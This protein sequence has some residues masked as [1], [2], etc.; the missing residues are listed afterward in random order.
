MCRVWSG[1]MCRGKNDSFVVSR[2]YAPINPQI[3]P[4]SN[5]CL[6]LICS[7][8]YKHYFSMQRHGIFKYANAVFTSA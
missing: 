5:L 8:T 4:Q 3:Y 7:R 2:Y 1:Q 6:K